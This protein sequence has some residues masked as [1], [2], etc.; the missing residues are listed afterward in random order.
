MDSI[1]SG[2]ENNSL[3]ATLS[4]R[5][6]A[7]PVTQ[8]SQWSPFGNTHTVQLLEAWNLIFFL[9]ASN[10]TSSPATVENELPKPLYPFSSGFLSSLLF[11]PRWPVISYVSTRTHTHTQFLYAPEQF[12][13]RE[14]SKVF[15]KVNILLHVALNNLSFIF[16]LL[17]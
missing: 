5:C 11:F 9:L 3:H 15:S 4:R 2:T 16:S 8:G 14:E 1:H 7:A 6:K 17:P 10:L 13:F 12:W